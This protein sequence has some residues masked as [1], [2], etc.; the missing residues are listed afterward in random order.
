MFED[1]VAQKNARLIAGGGGGGGANQA[2][3]G[4]DGG[5]VVAAPGEGPCHV[6]EPSTSSSSHSLSDSCAGNWC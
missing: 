4:G 5:G 3:R 6:S 1:Y 2:G